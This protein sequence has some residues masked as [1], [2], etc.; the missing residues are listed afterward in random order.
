MQVL[1][2][3]RIIPPCENHV[4]CVVFTFLQGLYINQISK[5]IFYEK[6]EGGEYNLSHRIL[7]Q[8]ATLVSVRWPKAQGPIFV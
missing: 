4:L 3:I 1:K 8:F 5:F 6:G 7:D 2:M